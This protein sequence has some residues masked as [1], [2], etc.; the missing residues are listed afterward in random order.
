M[1]VSKD[2]VLS[3]AKQIYMDLTEEEASKLS[4]DVEELVSET[5]VLDEVD[6]SAVIEDVS[7][8]EYHNAFR[9]DEVIDYK[10]RDMLLQCAKEVESN[11]FRI[12]KVV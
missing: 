11:M 8:L 1:A 12:P 2:K 9:K 6:V 10:E 7:V 5:R 4:A 3:L